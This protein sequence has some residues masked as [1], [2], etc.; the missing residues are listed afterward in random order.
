M[1]LRINK[2]TFVLNL[3]VF[4]IVLSE[5]VFAANNSV[6]SLLEY[7][8]YGFLLLYVCW[9]FLIHEKR[10]IGKITLSIILII[11][12]SV[13]FLIQDLS[14]RRK[15]ILLFTTVAIAMIACIS[16]KTIQTDESNR[17]LA[18][19]IFGS[20]VFSAVLAIVSGIGIVDS[21]DS[22][23]G[24]LFAFSGGLNL[25]MKFKNYFAADLI[26]VFLGI[27][28]YYRNVEKKRIDKIMLCII[29]L[30]IFMSNSRGGILLFVVAL[31]MLNYRVL[32]KIAKKQRKLL[33]V[34]IFVVGAF[35]GLYF[36]NNVILNVSTYAYRYRGLVNF[37]NHFSDDRYHM[38]LGISEKVYDQKL[39]YVLSVRTITGFD[40]S[41]EMA[42]LNILVKSG[43][44]GIVG[45]VLLYVEWIK[46]TV[47]KKDIVKK[48]ELITIIT[49]LL[50][51]SL[52]EAYIQSMH[53]I[54]AIYLYL[55][56]NKICNE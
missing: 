26:A 12:T 5:S 38:L 30:L 34:V 52:V 37:L 42:W 36:Y 39:D 46:I 14:I 28:F 32:G 17:R 33:V 18:Y 23:E 50:F 1:I 21:V 4:I 7:I 25:G 55:M 29:A 22:V 44:L 51:S 49:V 6:D 41:L 27:Y 9:S 2:K 19:T 3:A 47:K 31:L 35:V 11:L 53:C 16:G 45:Y 15:I 13:G 40:G 56:I 10:K 24:G 48:T 43:L 54:F 20:I 8:G